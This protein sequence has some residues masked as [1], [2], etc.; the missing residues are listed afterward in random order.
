MTI[1]KGP[2]TW[3]F[4][5]LRFPWPVYGPSVARNSNRCKK[6]ELRLPIWYLKVTSPLLCPPGEFGENRFLY[7]FGW[8]M[9]LSSAWPKPV[10]S[11]YIYKIS[12]Q[13]LIRLFARCVSCY[14][15]VTHQPLKM[16]HGAKTWNWLPQARI[17]SSFTT[18]TFLAHITHISKI[19]NQ[20]TQVSC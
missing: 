5:F 8:S 13:A 10:T 15:S 7:I 11:Q 6:W 3:K 4:H 17:P 18:P 12:F 9:P 16:Q 14:D 20:E 1:V 19:S 2:I